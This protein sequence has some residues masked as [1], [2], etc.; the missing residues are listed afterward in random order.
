MFIIFSPYYV[1][2]HKGGGSLFDSGSIL[3]KNKLKI[4]YI[5]YTINIPINNTDITK[6]VLEKDYMDYFTLQKILTELNED[7]FLTIDKVDDKDLFY[8]TETGKK[9][10]DMFIDKIPKLYRKSIENNFK[11]LKKEIEK[12]RQLIGHYF[13]RKDKDF[14]VILQAFEDDI[15]VF[16]LS[17]NVPDEDS[18]KNI[19]KKWK[20]NPDKIYSEFINILFK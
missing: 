11:S 8:L 3:A 1:I 18:A 10:V 5:F 14:T 12:N 20:E 7:G 15:T 13:Q 17:I 6:F 4:L 2:I 19:M 16:N 9:T